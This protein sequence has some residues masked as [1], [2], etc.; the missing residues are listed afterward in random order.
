LVLPGGRAGITWTT[1]ITAPGGV[2]MET[3]VVTPAEG[4]G[5]PLTNLVEVTT[6]EGVGGIAWAIVDPYRVYLPLVLR[7]R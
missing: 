4:R 7:E 6:E 1:V 5:G 3:I 2:W